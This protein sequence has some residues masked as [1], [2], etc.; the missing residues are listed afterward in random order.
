MKRIMLNKTLMLFLGCVVCGSL[1]FR[2]ASPAGGGLAMSDSEMA[3]MIGGQ[4]ADCNDCQVVTTDTVFHECFHTDEEV[5]DCNEDLSRCL[6][7]ILS[8]S[9]C[10]P[11]QGDGATGCDT[12]TRVPYAD[13]LTQHEYLSATATCSWTVDHYHRWRT[14]YFGCDT[15]EGHWCHGHGFDVACDASTCP[16]SVVDTA[17]TGHS[18]EC[19][20]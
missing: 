5:P 6:K 1:G 2:L 10:K 13:L 18:Y 19:G 12:D 16:G 17:A 9:S 15:S 4:C 11:N 3:N 7:N 20:C 14:I 8:T